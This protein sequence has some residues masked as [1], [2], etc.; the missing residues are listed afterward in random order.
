MIDVIQSYQVEDDEFYDPGLFPVKRKWSFSSNYVDD[1]SIFFTAS[2]NSTLRMLNDKLDDRSR[3]IVASILKET[4]PVYGKYRNRIKFTCG[5]CFYSS[6]K[7][8][9]VIEGGMN[10]TH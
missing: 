6:T 10:Y 9:L 3:K 5:K 1:N 2:I 7:E 4:N 8:C